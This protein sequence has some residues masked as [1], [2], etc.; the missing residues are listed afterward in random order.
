MSYLFLYCKK[1]LLLCAGLSF[2]VMQAAAQGKDTVAVRSLSGVE[3][4]EKA[5]PSAMRASV[6]VQQLDRAGI[7]R[8]GMEE[9]SEAVTRF[10]GVTVQDYGGIGG[11]K[12]VSVRSLGSQHTAV[13]YDGITITD[14]QRGQVDL[15]C[16]SLDNVESVTLA[17]GQ[18]DDI[19]Q[20]ARM[21]ASAGTLNIR[22]VEPAFDGRSSHLRIKIKGGSFGLFNP[23]A[24]YEQKLSDLFS[25]SAHAE[26]M[27]AKGD[28]PFTLTNGQLVT[29]ETRRNSDI[30]SLRTE[31]NV[32]GR[33]ARGGTMQAKLYY[34]DSERG[35]P[36]SVVLY[37]T[38]TNERLW[39]RNLFAQLHYKMPLSRM[40]TWQAQAKYN[41]T[42]SLYHNIDEQ[43]A[44]GLVA[45]RNTQQEY[46]GSTGLWLAPPVSAWSA[47]LSS[48][49][50]HTSLAGNVAGALS[51]ERLTSLTA[52]AAQYRDA[53]LTATASLL[54]TVISDEVK[55]GVRPADK[56]RLSPAVSFS[57]RP[58][59]EEA[60]RL[61]VSY[62][63]VY[64]VP[65]FTDLYYIRM[66]NT[67]LRPERATQFNA[68]LTWSGRVGTVARHAT[69][70]VDGYYNRVA[71]K[72]VAIPT[73]YVWKMMNLGRVGIRGAD[74]NASAECP[75][76]GETYVLLLSSAY[77]YRHAVDMTDPA[78]KNYRHQIPYTPRHSA[79]ASVT[80]EN[81]WVNAGYM[82]TLTGERY[83]LPQNIAANR[84]GGYAEHTVGL[85]KT[86]AT[87]ACRIRLQGE[88]LNVGGKS[89]DV[90]RYYPMPGRSF[91]FS[92]NIQY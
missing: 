39:D 74:V 81:P 21:Y 91:R 43:Y 64:R 66:G 13:S 88:A 28:Y 69:L 3:I 78:S 50:S 32:Y 9:L 54:A 76:R 46:Y 90:V 1:E 53:R 68:G 42:Y 31:A 36:G 34:Y 49:V 30:Q 63:D 82:L 16:F 87:R 48:D 19:F 24:R 29:Q 40:L 45:D 80:F 2:A 6:P 84:M 59:R 7:D 4:V 33:F 41:H 15:S 10:A 60:L 85:N 89:Y 67:N 38:R 86:I 83:V 57:F 11:L 71:D 17:I 73:M 55:Q 61:R 27:S 92:V 5:P 37:T 22:T 23:S 72:I 79:T 26:W 70:S 14:A 44:D 75:L 8:L 62:Q 12:T 47:S 18:A 35:L 20:P 56:R 65:T 77:S 52:L 51:P 25:I 58:L